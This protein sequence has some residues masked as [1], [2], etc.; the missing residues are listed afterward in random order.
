MQ[1][2]AY[3]SYMSVNLGAQTAQASP[4]QLVLILMNGL[5]EELARARAH[6]EAGRYE[7]KAQSLDR[8]VSILNGLSSALDTEAGGEVVDNLAELY[9]YCARRL[10]TAGYELSTGPVDEVAG[11]LATLQ[12]GWEGM[13]NRHG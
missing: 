10:F 4:V 6:I 8:C 3:S 13:Q 11:L 5:Q 1:Q 9:D 2:D 7:L 12:Q